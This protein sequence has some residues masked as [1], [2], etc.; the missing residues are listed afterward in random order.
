MAAFANRDPSSRGRQGLHGVCIHVDAIQGRYVSVRS[1][2]TRGTREQR[3]SIKED[4]PRRS[5]SRGERSMKRVSHVIALAAVTGF[6]SITAWAD[7]PAAAKP[8]E[9]GAQMSSLRMV[10]D[11]A[12][13]EM[14]APTT[15]ELKG[16]LEAERQARAAQA[17]SRARSVQNTAPEILPAE[18]SVVKHANGMVS[19]KL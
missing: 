10:R 4:L 12:T 18:K 8:A 1:Q 14:R 6:L 2:G 5:S 11:P 19:V 16:L 17:S 9:G 3:S 15:E 13:G 7:P